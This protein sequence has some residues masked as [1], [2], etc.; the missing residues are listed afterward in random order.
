MALKASHVGLS[1]QDPV[2]MERFYTRHFG[3]ERSR[4][5]PVAG[6]QIVM[7]KCGDF[8]IELFKAEGVAPVPPAGGDG[9]HFPGWRH[10]AFTVDDVDAKLAQMGSEAKVT[11]GPLGFDGF[12]PGWRTAWVADPEGNIIE[13]SQGYRDGG[14]PP[15]LSADS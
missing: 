15:E 11:L 12:I 10:L 8:Y 2:A 3:F 7:I 13:I 6:G 14:D 4:V 9:P 5:L 1:C